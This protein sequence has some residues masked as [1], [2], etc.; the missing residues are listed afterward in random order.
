[1]A[2]KITAYTDEITERLSDAGQTISHA[3]AE[4]KGRTNELGQTMV[5]KVEE[6]RDAAAG[7]LHQASKTLHSQ[8]QNLPRGSASDLA[9]SAAKR[10]DSA[11]GYMAEH[12]TSE[13]LADAGSFLKRHPG[14]SLLIG[15]AF[16]FLAGRA[17]RRD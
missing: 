14:K 17:F 9:H 16:G 2:E 11:A 13:M 4:A 8:A 6:T 7:A 10:L 5:D 12:D 1:M 3:V 15:M